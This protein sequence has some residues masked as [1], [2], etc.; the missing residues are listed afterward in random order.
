M[1]QHHTADLLQRGGRREVRLYV[2]SDLQNDKPN[3]GDKYAVV[4]GD[5][6]DWSA[7]NRNYVDIKAVVKIKD[8]N[9]Q[10]A[11]LPLRVEIQ[12]PIKTLAQTKAI[13]VAYKTTRRLRPICSKTSS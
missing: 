9:I 13:E 8:T 1:A 12:T 5:K 6:L 10:V 4:K 3:K 11:S 7:A 2:R